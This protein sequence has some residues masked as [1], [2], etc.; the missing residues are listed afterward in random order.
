MA[1]AVAQGGG[2]KRKGR[3]VKSEAREWEETENGR[4][5]KEE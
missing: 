1:G 5:E 3:E 4:W 2:R